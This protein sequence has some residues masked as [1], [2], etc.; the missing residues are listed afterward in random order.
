MLI[1]RMVSLCKDEIHKSFSMMQTQE[2][3]RCLQR[4]RVHQ[5]AHKLTDNNDKIEQNPCLSLPAELREYVRVK[6]LN[7]D[8]CWHSCELQFTWL[9]TYCCMSRLIISQFLLVDQASLYLASGVFIRRWLL[10][11]VPDWPPPS[12]TRIP[13]TSC[14]NISQAS[15]KSS[16]DT[17]PTLIILIYNIGRV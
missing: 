2:W 14:Q 15:V 6:Q 4:L 5:I 7:L 10:W 16:H 1:C 3:A 8:L 9:G 13:V 17:Q 11:L 12:V